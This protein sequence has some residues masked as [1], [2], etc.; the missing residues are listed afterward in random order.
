MVTF[1]VS[2]DVDRATRPMPALD[3]GEAIA[4]LLVARTEAVSPSERTLV[5]CK[6]TNAL[7]QAA[8]DAFY[9]H[10]P[11]VLSPDAIWLCL[12]QGFARHVNQNVDALRSRFVTHE[13]KKK[14]VVERPDMELG[15]PGPWHEVVAEFSQQIGANIGKKRDLVVCD[16]STTG[17]VER[18]ASEVVLMDAFQGY[19]EYEMMCGCGIPEIT[20]LGTPDDWRS[21]RTRAAVLGEFGLEA[22]T[23]ALLP[24]LDEL[25]RTSE[26]APDPTFWRSFFRYESGSGGSELTG[27]ILTLFPYL[28]D[29]QF[30]QG[31]TTRTP[32]WNKHLEDWRHRF[33]PDDRRRR[34]GAFLDSIPSS[35]ASA[36]VLCTDVRTGVPTELRFVGGLFGVVQDPATLALQPE[37]GWAIIYA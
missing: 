17:P 6:D 18:A 20:L 33:G 7:A 27:W 29:I 1:Q 5:A 34:D 22:W 8:Y 12:A 23:T 11:L 15:R 24:V 21:I 31:G 37:A 30:S 19:F 16:F 4:S 25:V 9:Q 13:G 36:P 14:L 26:G 35:L 32:V 2:R 28:D 3:R 10:F